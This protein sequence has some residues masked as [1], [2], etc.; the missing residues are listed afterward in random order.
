MLSKTFNHGAVMSILG[1]IVIWVLNF[2]ISWWNAYACGNIWLETKE[3]GGWQRLITWCG[4]IMSAI[5]FSWC[6]LIV[7]ALISKAVLPEIGTKV[8]M[9]SIYGG[10]IIIGPAAVLSGLFIWID[11]LVEAWRRRDFPSIAVAGWNTYAQI[12]NTVSLFDGLDTAF[13]GIGNIISDSDDDVKGKI[14]MLAV[15]LIAISLG[16][17]VLLTRY[18]IRKN[19]GVKLANTQTA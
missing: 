7:L 10:Y 15:I 17:G 2:G 16:M 6:I 14:I 4:A 19:M 18:I 5:G 9:L 8:M 1:L 13:K 3:I 11:S 12:S